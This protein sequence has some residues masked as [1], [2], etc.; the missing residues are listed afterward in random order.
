MLYRYGGEEKKSNLS[1]NVETLKF[2]FSEG[3]WAKQKHIS[4]S[5]KVAI[6]RGKTKGLG[7]SGF[8]EEI[9]KSEAVVKLNIHLALA[10]E[11]DG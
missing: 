8:R 7:R 4:Q 11:E 5:S 9:I 1:P 2:F 3:L 6:G 10:H